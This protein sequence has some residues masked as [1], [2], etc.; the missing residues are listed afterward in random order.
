MGEKKKYVEVVW[1]YKEIEEWIVY[2][3]ETEGP[4]RKGRPNARWEDRVKEYMHESY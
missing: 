3:S 1:S 4:R 2:V